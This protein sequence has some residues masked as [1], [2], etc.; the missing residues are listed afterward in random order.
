MAIMAAMKKVR[1]PNSV[2]IIIL[3]LAVNA[4]PNLS[5]ES[6]RDPADT[7]VTA[8]SVAMVRQRFTY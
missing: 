6:S 7:A 1:S 2:A 4:A 3:K 5:S 8:A